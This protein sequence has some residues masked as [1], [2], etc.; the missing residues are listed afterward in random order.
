VVRRAEGED[1]DLGPAQ[2]AEAGVD[3]AYPAVGVLDHAP[4]VVEPAGVPLRVGRQDQAPQKRDRYLAAVRV[5]RELQVEAPRGGAHV[6]EV[7]LVG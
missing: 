1:G 2:E 5:A 3:E 7:R 6:G 4:H